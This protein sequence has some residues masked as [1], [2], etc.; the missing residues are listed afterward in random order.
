MQLP[1]SIG[2]RRSRIADG[3]LL[4]VA[5][6][7][8]AA[9]SFWPQPLGIRLVGALIL[10]IGA[11]LIHRQLE[12]AL[13]IIRLD[14]TGGIAGSSTSGAGAKQETLYLLPGA[15]VHPWL[16]VARL[17]DGHGRHYII[18]ATTDSMDSNDFR[19]FRVFLRW[20]IKFND[21][22]DDA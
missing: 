10:F 4:L 21:L 3:I 17:R 12:P 22:T 18:L 5:T 13:K 16:T 19:R 8:V 9:W 2:L 11:C 14:S 7:I 15:V 1:I 6:S 20:R